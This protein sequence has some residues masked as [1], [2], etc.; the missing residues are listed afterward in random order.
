MPIV[1]DEEAIDDT[2]DYDNEKEYPDGQEDVP[3]KVLLYI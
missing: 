3:E 2:K 1:Q